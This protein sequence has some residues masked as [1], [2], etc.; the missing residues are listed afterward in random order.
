MNTSQDSFSVPSV[1]STDVHTCSNSNLHYRLT[2][3]EW[4]SISKDLRPAE[5]IVFFH[6]RTLDPFS[7][8]QLNLRVID[9][10]EATGLQKGT[11]SKAL[12]VLDCKGYI[13]LELIKVS[14]QVRKFPPGNQTAHQE[15]RQHTRKPRSTPGNIEEP[16][17]IQAEASRSPHTLNTLQTNQ[18]N[19]SLSHAFNDQE[20]ETSEV[21]ENDPSID[22]DELL[23]FTIGK[24]KQSS[25]IKRPRAY[26]KKCLRDDRDYWIDE[27]VKWQKSRTEI[28]VSTTPI[29][30][31]EVETIDQ[32]RRRL[33]KL[34]ES[35][36]CRPGI[37]NAIAAYPDLGLVVLEGELVEVGL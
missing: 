31:F 6:L 25:E 22:E 36:P 11:V 21:N 5:L 30:I 15:T 8:R 26:A 19:R 10:A 32:K 1:A 27:F 13:D 24:V 3:E 34:W 37:R 14:V 28:A 20:R 17:P 35:I 4:L 2:N 23:Q 29:P 12:K 16:E 18:T 9:I 33:I 7:D